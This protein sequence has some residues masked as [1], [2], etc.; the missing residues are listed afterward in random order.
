MTEQSAVLALGDAVHAL[1]AGGDPQDVL[2]RSLDACVRTLGAR[3]AGVMVRRRGRALEL[4]TATSHRTAELEL[5]QVQS[6]EGP[7]VD[8][9][10]TGRAVVVTGA[11]EVRSRWAETG[12]AIVGAGYG[13]VRAF[14]LRRQELVFGG[15]N[16]FGAELESPPGEDDLAVGQA[17]AD[18]VTVVLLTPPAAG[19]DVEERV[20][21]AIAGRA[22][23]EQAKGVLAY[24]LRIDV[25]TAYDVLA[26]RARAAGATVTA[27]ARRTVA[28]AQTRR[29]LE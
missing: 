11:E 27:E 9:I 22:V 5:F 20:R 6:S 16:V 29:A 24:Q 23:I 17:F 28:A 19:V 10:D 26:E 21:Q 25:A 13:S 7:C 3:A 14:P 1:A 4:V 15:L 2:L 12:P 18:L 8:V